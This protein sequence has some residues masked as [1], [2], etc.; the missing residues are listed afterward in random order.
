MKESLALTT[1]NSVTDEHNR[2]QVSTNSASSIQLRAP[3]VHTCKD[4]MRYM[5]VCTM[6]CNSQVVYLV[7]V[8][9][10]LCRYIKTMVWLL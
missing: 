8:P 4:S 6:S 5:Y 10:I 2:A 7:R 1:L 9:I 3:H